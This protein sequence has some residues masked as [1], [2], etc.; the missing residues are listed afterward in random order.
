MKFTSLRLGVGIALVGLALAGGTARAQLEANLGALNDEN[1]RGYL[2]P[3]ATALSAT[4][5]ASVFQTG[6]IPRSKPTFQI[7]ANVMGVTFDDADR[8]YTPTDPPGFESSE[9]VKA[10]TVIGD[11]DAVIQEG[12]AGTQLYHP[13]GFD[14]ENFTIAAPQLSVGGFMGT[15]LLVRWISLDLGDA[16]L[17]NL[18]LFGIGGQHSLSQYFLEAPVDVAAGVMYQSFKIG[19]GLVDA[20]TLQFNVTGSKRFGVIEPYVGIGYDTFDMKGEYTEDTT[21]EGINVKFDREN[22]IHLTVG[23]RLN[24]NYVILHGE[25]NAAA[26]SGVA[27]GLSVGL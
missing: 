15:K 10:P 5:N 13:G 2:Q 14:L 1:A 26:E 18:E 17:G 11:P 24:F 3:L 27:A 12:Q 25:F 20:S 8:T 7:Q 4:L 21:G 9:S 6:D 16:D 23:G 19:D 22:N